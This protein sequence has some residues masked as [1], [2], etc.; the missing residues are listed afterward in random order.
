[1]LVHKNLWLWAKSLFLEKHSLFNQWNQNNIEADLELQ[2]SYSSVITK[3]RRAMSLVQSN[4]V[5][6][7]LQKV[8]QKALP[9]TEQNSNQQ[10][11]IRNFQN[12]I[13]IT[14]TNFHH[15]LHIFINLTYNYRTIFNEEEEL[16][17]VKE[18]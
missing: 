3:S 15:K 11:V 5:G 1:M 4:W 9:K 10:Y 2:Q 14:V 7:F 17:V 18:D 12:F 8:K 13:L 6:L 16:E